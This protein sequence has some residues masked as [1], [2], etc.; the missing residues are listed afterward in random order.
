MAAGV[1]SMRTL[2]AG[3]WGRLSAQDVNTAISPFSVAVA[4]GMTVNGAREATRDEMLTVLGAV[5]TDAVN[6]GYNAVAQHVESLAGPVGDDGKEILLDAANALFGQQGVTWEPPFLDALAAS[7]GAGVQQVDFAGAVETA[8]GAV[9]DWVALQTKDKIPEL[10]ARGSLDPAT[11]LVLVNALYLK[12]PW[13]KEFRKDRTEDGDFHLADGTV[14]SVP[15]MRG[16]VA[17]TV[18]TGDGWTAAQVP[19]LGRALAMTVVLP[20]VGRQAEVDALLAE[21]GLEQLVRP[22]E[23]TLVELTMPRWTFRSKSTLAPVLGV[24]G[25]PTAFSDSADFSAM[26]KDEQ[27]LLQAVQHEVYV[28]VDEEGTEAAAATGASVGV[29]SAPVSV[30]LVLDRPFFFVV[31]DVEHGTPLFVGHVGDPSS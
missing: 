23:P 21:D 11:R 22:G 13:E 29:S 28:K 8:R 17:S 25:M 19:Y 4:L 12:A 2:G 5:D 27:L 20:D 9:N 14:V 24:L 31:H 3:L 15:M 30:P 16:S 6:A 7:Y 18:T 10:F 26:T 1:A